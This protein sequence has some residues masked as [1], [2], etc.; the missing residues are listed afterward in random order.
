[1]PR[2]KPLMRRPPLIT[3]IMACSSATMIGWLRSGSALP[4]IAM[5]IFEVRRTSADAVTI[6]EGI[7]P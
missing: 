3:S 6:G 2:T 1:M 4:R 7:S 5:R